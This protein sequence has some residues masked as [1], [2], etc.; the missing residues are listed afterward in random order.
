MADF[1]SLAFQGGSVLKSVA[2][3]VKKATT[4]IR[5]EH[6]LGNIDIAATH[7]NIYSRV[8]KE[9]RARPTTFNAKHG[10]MTARAC[11]SEV[12]LGTQFKKKLHN[13]VVAC[14]SRSPFSQPFRLC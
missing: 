9:Y 13:E 8:V 11:A 4:A 14:L 6:G 3:E 7:T 12:S 10:Y 1:L 5:R 2:G